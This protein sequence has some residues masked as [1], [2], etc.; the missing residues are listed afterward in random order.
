MKWVLAMKRV[1][2]GWCR[3]R[4]SWWKRGANFSQLKGVVSLYQ[5]MVRAWSCLRRVRFEKM[6]SHLRK[7]PNMFR[8]VATTDGESWIWVMLS[9]L[10]AHYSAFTCLFWG[11]VVKHVC[12][13]KRKVCVAIITFSLPL[14]MTCAIACMWPHIKHHCSFL[15][16]YLIRRHN[17]MLWLLIHTK[18]WIHVYHVQSH[19]HATGGMVSILQHA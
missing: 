14:E 10:V 2:K 1:I 4:M 6:L 8:S 17:S 19:W 16:H 9:D 11:S 12:V 15:N 7:S 13:A 3:W 18:R 5:M